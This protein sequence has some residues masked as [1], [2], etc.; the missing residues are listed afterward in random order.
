MI[1]LGALRGVHSEAS[2]C[3]RQ[4]RSVPPQRLGP[5][6]MEIFGPGS[7]DD[8]LPGRFAASRRAFTRWAGVGEGASNGPG[9]RSA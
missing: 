1:D 3:A 6:I 5:A 2:A 4:Y 7:L 8:E 9:G